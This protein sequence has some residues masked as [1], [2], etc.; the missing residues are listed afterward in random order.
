MHF[1]TYS[2][3]GVNCAVSTRSNVYTSSVLFQTPLRREGERERFTNGPSYLFSHLAPTSTPTPST[4]RN[5]VRMENWPPL[6]FSCENSTWLFS[7]EKTS[8]SVGGGAV[9]SGWSGF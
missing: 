2:A 9:Y 5:L 3:L 7:D 6:N 1:C 4:L 8:A